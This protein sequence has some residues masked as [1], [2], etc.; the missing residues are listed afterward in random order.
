MLNKDY[1][2]A[3]PV[4]EIFPLRLSSCY[5]LNPCNSGGPVA[6]YAELRLCEKLSRCTGGTPYLKAP[7]SVACA[8]DKTCINPRRPRNE[9]FKSHAPAVALEKM[10]KKEAPLVRGN[11]NNEVRLGVRGEWLIKKSATDPAAVPLGRKT[12]AAAP[13]I[14]ACVI[15][16]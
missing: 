4:G 9:I 5:S 10:M 1:V 15:S 2:T 8:R 11:K 3:A 13:P 14:A 7:K 16:S 6:D 12:A